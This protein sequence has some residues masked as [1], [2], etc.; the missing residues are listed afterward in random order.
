MVCFEAARAL[1]SLPDVRDEDLF[2][3]VTMLKINVGSFRSVTKFAAVRILN[4]VFDRILVKC[5]YL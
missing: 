4:Q 3:V 2:P 5:S 1:V